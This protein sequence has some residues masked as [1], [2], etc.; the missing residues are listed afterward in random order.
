[1]LCSVCRLHKCSAEQKWSDRQLRSYRTNATGAVC[2]Q[3]RDSGRTRKSKGTFQCAAC[4]LDKTRGDFAGEDLKNKQKKEKA[5]DEYTL[6]CEPCKT[7]ETHI[8]GVL[9]QLNGRLC[10]RCRSSMYKH[11]EDCTVQ[12]KAK[13]TKEDLEF[14]GFRWTNRTHYDTSNVPYYERL[15]VISET[16]SCVKERK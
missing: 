9:D 4:R 12:Y 16:T 11:K 6:V 1:M 14:F 8:K 7:R 2:L 3:C 13:I 5:G 10:K 15:G